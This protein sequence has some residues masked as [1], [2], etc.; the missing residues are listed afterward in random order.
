M[1]PLLNRGRFYWRL[2]N[3]ID[4][5]RYSRQWALT[6]K[7]DPCLHLVGTRYPDPNKFLAYDVC[8]QL[9]E[10][11]PSVPTTPTAYLIGKLFDHYF[12]LCSPAD[13]ETVAQQYL[14]NELGLMDLRIC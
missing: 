5:G 6:G 11:K 10:I 7:W 14:N 12:S 3:R 13:P 1:A 9:T 8:R 4:A 2:V